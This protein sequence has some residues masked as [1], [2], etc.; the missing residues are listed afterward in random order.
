VPFFVADLY[1]NDLGPTPN[2]AALAADPRIVGVI[3]KATQGTY[4]APG[5]L[6]ANWPR[7]RAV[8]IRGAYHFG[9][10]NSSG[11][12]QADFFLSAMATAGGLTDGDMPA[13]WDLEGAVWSSNQQIIDVSSAFAA[14]IL[15]RTGRSPLLYTGATVRD[16]G[17]TDRMGFDGIW[18][19]HLDMSRAGWRLADYKLWQF[20][21]DGRLYDPTSAVYGFP[22]QIPGWGGT[23]MSVVMDGGVFASSRAAAERVLVGG[24]GL[25][26]W[27]LLGAAA[28]LL[29]LSR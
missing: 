11:T 19:P 3:L 26:P 22:T 29:Y 27:L 9:D 8:G 4:Y 21:G 14:R 15:Q 23:D 18:T 1:A 2:F 28:A 5:W 13:I 25:T 24:W 16:R 10:P 12:A 20:A 7:A 17:I 6:M